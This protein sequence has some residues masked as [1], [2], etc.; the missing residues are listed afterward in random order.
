MLNFVKFGINFPDSPF[1]IPKF[2][3][4]ERG[5]RFIPNFP[6]NHVITITNLPNEALLLLHYI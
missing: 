2:Q 1:E 4:R 5:E 6:H 3:K